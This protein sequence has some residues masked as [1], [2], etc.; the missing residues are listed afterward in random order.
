MA[1]AKV[2]LHAVPRPVQGARHLKRSAKRR[3]LKTILALGL[4]IGFQGMTA[5]P[6]AVATTPSR[7]VHRDPLAS[8]RVDLFQPALSQDPT[9]FESILDGA[10][11]MIRQVPK[12]EPA[13]LKG[14]PLTLTDADSMLDMDE[15]V[16]FGGRNVPRW[17]LHTIL[18]AAHTTGVDPSYMVTL[19]DVESS[20]LPAAK[21]STSS[22]EGLFQFIDSTW[23]ETVFNHA[24]D[25]GFGAASAALK[26]VDGEAVLINEK[27]R[28]WV[29]GLRRDPYFSA[30]M[31]GEL[32]KDVEK[33]LRE[34]GER[35]LAE[36]E[37]YIAHFLG[38]NSAVK[39]LQALDAEPN[40]AAS[41][42]FPKAARANQ[43]LFTERQGK[44]RRAVSLAEFYDKIDSK[45][46]RRLDRYD[47]MALRIAPPS[48]FAGRRMEA[49]A[50][51]E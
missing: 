34:D 19:A 13:P 16:P 6:A 42:L 5:G 45:I 11:A 18:N 24:A 32:I 15:V 47:S 51:V 4:M 12:A 35:E 23:L 46:V 1:T 2:P 37:L 31:A 9:L 20:L 36:T 38:A 21:A 22:A 30:L 41:K 3:T 49:T 33:A 27:D 7:F 29:M 26:M 50:S 48:Q 10:F 39:F 43:G 40:T 25:Y 14:T 44:R 17:L 8:A 28:G